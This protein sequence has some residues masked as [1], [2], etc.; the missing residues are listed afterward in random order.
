MISDFILRS[1]SYLRVGQ[2]TVSRIDH[3]AKKTLV[4]DD[5]KLVIL[6]VCVTKSW[7]ELNLCLKLH[8]LN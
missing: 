8:W 1:I 4:C 3:S 2:S 6:A 7:L 5:S